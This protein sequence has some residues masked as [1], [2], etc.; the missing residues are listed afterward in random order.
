VT[1]PTD[2]QLEFARGMS[3]RQRDTLRALAMMPFHMSAAERGDPELYALIRHKLAICHSTTPE[4]VGPFMWAA[5]DAG[6]A[7]AKMQTA[8]EL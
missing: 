4:V 6:K 7:I 5:T 3:R 2:A 8:G 1:K